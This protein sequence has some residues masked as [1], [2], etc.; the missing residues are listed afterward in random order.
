MAR[1]VKATMPSGEV[2]ELEGVPE[3]ATEAQIRAKVQA[4]LGEAPT[5]LSTSWL[6]TAKVLG[7]AA[8]R[9]IASAGA[10]V[11]DVGRNL[12]T[13]VRE[14]GEVLTGR[15]GVGDMQPLTDKFKHVGEVAGM[16]TQPITTG[17]RYGASVAEG[18]AG[19][20]LGGVGGL[21]K[22][23]LVGAAGGLGAEA[24]GQ[25]LSDNPLA[26]IAGALLGS[27]AAGAVGAAK[28]TRGDLARETLR[29]AKDTDL[30]KAVATMRGQRQAFAERGG[31]NA[32]I[33]LSQAMPESSNVDA[34][35]EKLANSR[36]GTHTTAQLRAQPKQT[37][38]LVEGELMQLPGT[39]RPWQDLANRAQEAAT[40]RIQGEKAE[41]SDRWARAYTAESVGRPK[42]VPAETVERVAADLLWRA[43]EAG[44]R[45]TKAMGL[46]QL[47]ARL[48]DPQGNPITDGQTL[49]EI[50]K[51]AAGKAKPVSIGSRGL[52]V[53]ASKFLQRQIGETRDAFGEA[54]EPFKKANT[55]FKGYTEAVV[56]PLKKSVIGDIAG[57]AGAQPDRQAVVG[58]LT[59]VFDQGTTPGA[60]RSE[61]LT[62]QKQLQ[63]TDPEAYT[64]AAKTWI[65]GKITQ[66]AAPTDNRFPEDFAKKL[67]QAF[68]SETATV[69][70]K[71][72]GLQDILV[73]M[74]RAKGEPDETFLGLPK[75]MQY[76]AA[77]SRR[78]S[79]FQGASSADFDRI[80]GSP[81][82][83]A[84]ARGSL[85]NILRPGF[86]LW[87]NLLRGDAMQFVDKLITSP[88]G[89]EV[90]RTLAKENA[91]S[92]KAQTAL[93]AFAATMATGTPKPKESPAE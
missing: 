55:A 7:S 65:S 37:S 70:E 20:L 79:G 90:L 27:G 11:Q 42:Q 6:D 78:P 75:L 56:E 30:D 9:G 36:H 17:Q 59:K 39:Q 50:L 12:L 5:E 15:R 82:A 58:H 80:A 1:T 18:A 41:A 88:E 33:N 45:T 22:S 24:A 25:A 85:L 43:E 57:R 67:V 87:D 34:M 49:N 31:E 62:L 13:G 47:A 76:I 93:A 61:I 89:V 26:R 2:V 53:A 4:K 28:T 92:R 72:K 64:D 44:F 10:M 84:M 68:G 54:F 21:V 48:Y 19:G 38:A 8:G 83:N 86:I 29:D 32:G 51:D 66:A 73:G 77:S 14:T 46:K 16:G 52:D 81:L 71:S 91:H 69:T 63:R 74:A 23:G 35:V 40:K 60:A 3:T